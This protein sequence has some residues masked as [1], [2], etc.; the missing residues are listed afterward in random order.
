MLV[1]IVVVVPTAVA[2]WRYCP[3]S[4]PLRQREVFK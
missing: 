2:I 1:A 3:T 4:A